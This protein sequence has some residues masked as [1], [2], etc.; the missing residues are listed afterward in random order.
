MDKHSEHSHTISPSGKYLFCFQRLYCGNPDYLIVKKVEGGQVIYAELYD[1]GFT[2]WPY[3]KV[4]WE[5]NVKEDILVDDRI[6]LFETDGGLLALLH[7]SEYYDE[8]EGCN[9]LK[10]SDF[11]DVCFVGASINVNNVSLEHRMVKYAIN[12]D[13][14]KP[15]VYY[16][17]GEEVHFTCKLFVVEDSSGDLFKQWRSQ[18]KCRI[19]LNDSSYNKYH[20]LHKEYLATKKLRFSWFT[21]E[22]PWDE[23]KYDNT[24]Y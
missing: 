1:N 12:F 11:L 7:G 6:Y 13:Q 18:Q 4:Y 10:A 22:V 5:E 2:Y 17:L 14:E 19:M 16:P 3:G 8:G 23:F 21:K 20:P 9:E 24:Y 15:R